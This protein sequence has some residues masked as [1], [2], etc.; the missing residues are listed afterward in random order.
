M[1]VVDESLP[2]G[3]RIGIGDALKREP[4]D[5]GELT[6]NQPTGYLIDS[7]WAQVSIAEGKAWNRKRQGTI[8]DRFTAQLMT[9]ER[10]K[11][12]RSKLSSTATSQAHRGICHTCLQG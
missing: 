5:A 10:L 6:V 7:N 12:G 8:D 1:I 3:Y 11:A 2:E 4:H 9:D